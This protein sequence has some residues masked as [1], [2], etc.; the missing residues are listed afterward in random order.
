MDHNDFHLYI[1]VFCGRTRENDKLK[2]G[3]LNWTWK[4]THFHNRIIKQFSQEGCRNSIPGDLQD[5]PRESAK[6]SG[7]NSNADPALSRKPGWKTSQGSFQNEWLCDSKAWESIKI[8][9]LLPLPDTCW[10]DA[11]L[12]LSVQSVKQ[13]LWSSSIFSSSLFNGLSSC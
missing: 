3:G 1:K 8:F 4:R 9:L 2:L 10:Y 7:L 6:Q 13:V 12:P 5:L 11:S